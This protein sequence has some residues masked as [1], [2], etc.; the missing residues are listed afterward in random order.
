M[1]KTP[2]TVS[3]L[4][5]PRLSRFYGIGPNELA[6]IPNNLLR[7][8]IEEMRTIQAEESL[9]RILASDMPHADK[10]D[11]ERI[12]S[13][14]SRLAETDKAEQVDVQSEGGQSLAASLGIKVE[15]PVREIESEEENN[16][17]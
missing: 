15:V 2:R 17:A 12:F 8:Y 1:P 16:G 3:L 6:S 13:A 4:D 14:L 9:D 7:I 11:R 10:S 5:F